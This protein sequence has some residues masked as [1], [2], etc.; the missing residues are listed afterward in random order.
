MWMDERAFPFY[1]TSISLLYLAFG[2]YRAKTR[3]E[4]KRDD[5]DQLQR[6]VDI[7]VWLLRTDKQHP[8][9]HSNIPSLKRVEL[10][11]LVL[12]II[13]LIAGFVLL[14]F[15]AAGAI[16]E[17]VGDVQWLLFVAY[18]R[19]S[20]SIPLSQ[21]QRL[22]QIYTSTLSALLLTFP[23]ASHKHSF[24]FRIS[25]VYFVT[26]IVYTVR[27]IVPLATGQSLPDSSNVPPGQFAFIYALLV[28]SGFLI[29]AF[30]PSKLKIRSLEVS[31]TYLPLS[32]G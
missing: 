6:Y 29:P 25:I 28:L 21:R 22:K 32:E 9:L 18:V 8:S 7:T 15:T 10:T 20:L 23:A 26:L 4:V 5:I 2:I 30:L 3:Q 17:P 24:S 14:G 11:Q 19:S 27:Y 1:A 12:E 13:R 16:R 31:Y